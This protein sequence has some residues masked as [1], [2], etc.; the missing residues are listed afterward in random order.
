[1][2]V[3]RPHCNLREHLF[4]EPHRRDNLDN[5]L[6]CPAPNVPDCIS[7]IFLL[8]ELPLRTPSASLF[9]TLYSH[10]ALFISPGVRHD[11][12]RGSTLIKV[13][14]AAQTLSLYNLISGLTCRNEPAGAQRRITGE[15]TTLLVQ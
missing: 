6:A 10:C 14:A 13:D 3:A 1:M 12:M 5:L 2:N 8:A 7:D 11:A 9:K 4:I 15:N